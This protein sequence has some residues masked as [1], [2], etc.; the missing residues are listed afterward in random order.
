LSLNLLFISN[1]NPPLS[2]RSRLAFTLIELLVVIAIIAILAGM[3]LPALSKA[4]S[5]AYDTQCLN[6]LRQVGIALHVYAD[7]NKG[8]L[9]VAS[10]YPSLEGGVTNADA[11]RPAISFVLANYL[12]Y[13]AT[14]PPQ[15]SSVLRCPMDKVVNGTNYYKTQGSSYEW[16]TAA[17]ND[18][19]ANP[20]WWR[21][22]SSPEKFWVM[23]DYLP[24]HVG[25]RPDTNGLRG[26]MYLLFADGHVE[27]R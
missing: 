13:N 9:P 12:G 17:N 10:S 5:K 1:M 18:P 22:D 23:N 15:V 7:D 4:K 20:R 24:W 26:S 27:R 14:N 25:G 21:R 19:I 6:N 8:R 11:R 16:N 3:L 2:P